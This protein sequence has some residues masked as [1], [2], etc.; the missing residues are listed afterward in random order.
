MT[1][2]KDLC[3]VRT[4]G[5]WGRI[6]SLIHFCYCMGWCG[7]SLFSCTAHLFL[8]NLLFIPQSIILHN[9]G[10]KFRNTDHMF[11]CWTQWMLNVWTWLQK[12][13]SEIRHAKR[14]TIRWTARED[15]IVWCEWTCGQIQ[16]SWLTNTV[17]FLYL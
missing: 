5:R 7:I 4:W 15:I 17:V 3:Q 13:G 10:G 11:S 12:G 14:F 2:L 8:N 6:H 16:K 9:G 1:S